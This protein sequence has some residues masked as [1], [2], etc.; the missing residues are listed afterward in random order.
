M[1]LPPHLLNPFPLKGSPPVHDAPGAASGPR[2][3]ITTLPAC[4]VEETST[5]SRRFPPT[6]QLPLAI[7]G[8][9]TARAS[10]L[11][12]SPYADLIP[13]FWPEFF[14]GPLVYLRTV[15]AVVHLHDM[16]NTALVRAKR[17]GENADVEKRR[18]YR[19]AHGIP[20]KR[21]F[22]LWNVYTEEEAKEKEAAASADGSGSGEGG[23]VTDDGLARAAARIDG[24]AG[25]ARVEAKAKAAFEERK[26]WF[27]L[28]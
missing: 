9:Y 15:S 8:L 20:E 7:L 21:L 28:F 6:S 13:P 1:H 2:N 22:G 14:Q 19:K 4:A 24:L 18:L 17:L 26:K 16:H 27:G 23:R 5:R 12:T 25:E 11:A 10:F 3:L